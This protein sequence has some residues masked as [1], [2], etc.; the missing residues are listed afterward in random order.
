[1]PRIVDLDQVRDAMNPERE[2]GPD[3]DLARELADEYVAANPDQFTELA[4]KTI[5]ECVTAVDVFRAAG[6]AAEQSRIETWLLHH[7]EP[8]SIGGAAAP[9]VRVI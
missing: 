5:E 9:T 3:L 4:T 8:Q 2:G 6:M 1:M 7:F